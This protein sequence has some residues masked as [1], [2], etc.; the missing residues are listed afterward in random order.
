MA[1]ETALRA[2]N[3]DWSGFVQSSKYNWEG[4]PSFTLEG[5][6]YRCAHFLQGTQFDYLT[7]VTDTGAGSAQV[8][9]QVEAKESI[10]MAGAYFCV[11]LPAADYAGAK[12][13][14]LD[15]DQQP[16]STLADH[17]GEMKEQFRIRARGFKVTGTRRTLEVRTP[18]ETELIVRQDFVDQPDYLNDP[19]PRL[20]LVK[21]D[22]KQKVAD[23]QVYFTILPG[24]AKKGTTAHTSYNIRASGTIDREPVKLVLEPKNPGRMFSGVGGNFRMQYPDLDAQVVDYCFNHLNVT[25]GRIAFPWNE[26]QPAEGSD[27]SAKT[28]AGGM[29]PAFYAQIEMARELAQRHI[30]IILSVWV[31]PDW[32]VDHA[33]KLPKGVKLDDRKLPQIASSIANYITFLKQQYGIEVAL[34]SFNE[35]DYGVEVHQSSEEHA[36][37]NRTIGAELAARGLV[38]KMILGDTGAGTLEAHQLIRATEQDKSIHPYLG[39]ISFHNYHGLTVEDLKA[40]AGSA[41][42]LNLPLLA[43]EG[44]ADSAA[45]RYPLVWVTPWFAQLETDQY[46]R[47]GAA[48]QPSSILPWQLNADYSL[49]AGGGIYGDQGQL[50]PTQRFWALKQLGTLSGAFWLPVSVDRP[51]ISSAALGDIARGAYAVHLTNNGASRPATINGIPASVKKM[52]IYVTDAE[53]GMQLMAIKGVV[54]GQVSFVLEAQTFTSLFSE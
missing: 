7:Q 39:A 36:L 40:W 14:L 43:D 4:H 46:V 24:S 23:F 37:A 47:I 41:R 38:T 53:R 52:R 5:K 18:E 26:W 6:T 32:A 15:A 28:L 42:A 11:N 3:P 54:D 17:S 49:L 27:A 25:W 13:E 34:F 48:C 30:P 8:D 22:P 44:G 20:Q 35:T 19:R 45:H 10:A 1:F 21:G 9:L 33:R 31:P 16:P 50:R 51:N 29:S 2:V 12:F